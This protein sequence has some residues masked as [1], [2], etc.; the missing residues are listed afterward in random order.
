MSRFG[1]LGRQLRSSR[2]LHAARKVKRFANLFLEQLEDR[3]LLSVPPAS[4]LSG[5]YHD[6]LQR[7]ADASGQAHWTQ[8][9]QAGNSPAEVALQI[10][11]S[12]EYHGKL[13]DQEFSA[14]LGRAAD[15]Q[16]HA[17]FSSWLDAGATL[18]QVKAEIFGSPEYFS[19]RGVPIRVIWMACTAMC[20]VAASIQAG[21]RPLARRWMW[22][23]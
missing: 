3:I 12:S 6:L 22:A 5:L 21:R 20:W 2:R 19:P 18:E 9:L 10:V 7:D 17:T 16:G 8:A 15:A 23:C 13:V 11:L 14:L 1:R 4:F